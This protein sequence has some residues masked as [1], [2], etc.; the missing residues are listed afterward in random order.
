MD[1]ITTRLNFHEALKGNDMSEAK[2]EHT[3]GPR[4]ADATVRY[5]FVE[6]EWVAYI[7]EKLKSVSSLNAKAVGDLVRFAP[8]LLRQRDELLEAA[9]A[10]LSL[11][12]ICEEIGYVGE[13][14]CVRGGHG[15][16]RIVGGQLVKAYTQGGFVAR[17]KITS[18]LRAAITNAERKQ[19]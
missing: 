16:L 18:L 15:V 13:V 7:P 1:D 11:P 10:A 4:W 19:A 6:S 9:K 2:A 3:P 5:D 8:D 14:N 17:N 12:T